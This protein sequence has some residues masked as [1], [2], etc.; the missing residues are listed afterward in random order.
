MSVEQPATKKTRMTYNA[1]SGMTLEDDGWNKVKMPYPVPLPVPVPRPVKV[2]VPHPVKV[3][4][5][6]KVPTPVRTCSKCESDSCNKGVT[7][8]A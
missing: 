7:I 3:P 8:S 6:V 4:V 5:P 2:P 1:P